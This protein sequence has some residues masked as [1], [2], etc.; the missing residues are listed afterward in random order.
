MS[1]P[2]SRSVVVT[3]ASTGIGRATVAALVA[4]GMHVWPTVR[5]DVDAQGLRDEFGDAV[6]PLLADLTDDAA[7]AAAG[8]KVCAAGPLH[9]LVNNAG[10]ALT[11]PL[12]HLPLD[13]LRR[14]LDINLVGQL[15]VTQAMLPA[16]RVARGRGERARIVMIGSVGGRIASPMIGPYHAAKFGLAGLSGS[17]RAELA[18]WG[19]GVV[20]LEPGS[21]ATPI[22]DRALR[23]ADEVFAAMPPEAERYEG[24]VRAARADAERTAAHGIP[25]AR[26]AEVVVRSLTRRNPAPR[27]M[28]GRD[29]QLVGVL[30]RLLPHRV[31]FRLTAAR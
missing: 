31:I 21:I 28:I 4:E 27:R 15:A 29:A 6:T 14:Q 10:A 25:P 23:S 26:V 16:L 22:W 17:L 18:P 3:G 8:K 9:G 19:I 1:I 13:V 24:Q 20:L 12:E 2:H 30:T 7:V 5:R 11:G